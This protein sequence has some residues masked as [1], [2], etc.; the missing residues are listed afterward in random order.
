[1]ETQN[2]TA[3]IVGSFGR[4]VGW[5]ARFVECH[6]ATGCLLT[7][8]A[9]ANR[10]HVCVWVYRVTESIYA[11]HLRRM[12]NWERKNK[13]LWIRYNNNNNN[14]NNSAKAT[15]PNM[16]LNG[17]TFKHCLT[18]FRMTWILVLLWR[19]RRRQRRCCGGAVFSLLSLL[20]YEC[21]W[22]KSEAFFGFEIFVM[23]FANI[24]SFS[25]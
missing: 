1:M 10:I 24:E 8:V 9:I 25:R 14:N 11:R 4:S 5:F 16:H 20:S 22:A 6:S 21:F 17:F 7:I 15:T 3:T 18:S 13:Q 12:S 19:R 23:A 2:G